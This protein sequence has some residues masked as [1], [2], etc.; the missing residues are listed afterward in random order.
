MAT[1]VDTEVSKLRSAGLQL[2]EDTKYLMQSFGVSKTITRNYCTITELKGSDSMQAIK[3]PPV[4]ENGPFANIS[5]QSKSIITQDGLLD[6]TS[7]EQRS[8]IFCDSDDVASPDNC[9]SEMIL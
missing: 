8:S 9:D 7:T 6:F 3:D 5:Y 2:T 4:T 1:F